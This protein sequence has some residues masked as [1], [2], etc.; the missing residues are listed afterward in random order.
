[1]TSTARRSRGGP[2]KLLS[3]NL[4]RPPGA[5]PVTPRGRRRYGAQVLSKA[6]RRSKGF[7]ASGTGRAGCILGSGERVGRH[8]NPKGGIPARSAA[9]GDG[10]LAS[11]G[12]GVD[13]S[14]RRRLAETPPSWLRARLCTRG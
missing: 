13:D 8:H 9:G 4:K 11:Y 5:K 1:M 3:S 2:R 14:A 7:S 10:W 12:G 6:G